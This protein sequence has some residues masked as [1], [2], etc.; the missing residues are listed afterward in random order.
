MSLSNNNIISNE[1]SN[2]N[3]IETI[4]NSN[5]NNNNLMNSNQNNPNQDQD[6]QKTEN[7]LKIQKKIGNYILLDTIGKGTFSKVTLGYHIQTN[8]TVAIKILEKDK[9]QDKIDIER[10]NREITILKLLYHPNISQLYETLSTSHNFYIMMEYI[11]GGDLFEYISTNN[12]L[13][14][15]K[16]C[17]YFRQLISAI[18]YLN[19]LGIAHRDI[20][21]ENI[22]LNSTKTTL[23][24]IDFGLSNFCGKDEMLNSSCGSPCYASPEMIS[25]YPYYGLISDIWS[26]GIVLYCMLIGSL[27]FDDEN[28]KILY[29][30]ITEGKF[31]VPSTLSNEAIDLLKKLLCVNPQKRITLN[32]IKNHVW[33]NMDKSILYKG[34]FLKEKKINVDFNVVHKIKEK[35]F[36]EDINVTENTIAQI[37]RNNGCNKYS[38]TYHLYLKMYNKKLQ[39]DEK[40]LNK[41][42]T[43]ILEIKFK[44]KRDNNIFGNNI[45]NYDKKLNVVVINNIISNSSSIKNIKKK[46][47]IKNNNKNNNHHNKNQKNNNNLAQTLN[48]NNNNNTRNNS[49]NNN[50]TPHSNK[51][52]NNINNTKKK[53]NTNLK[54]EILTD[55]LRHNKKKAKIKSYS[56]VN[57]RIK[58][59]NNTKN[60]II[61]NKSFNSTY[62]NNNNINN[63]NYNNRYHNYYLNNNSNNKNNNKNIKNCNNNNNSNVMKSY[64]NFTLTSNNYT[65]NVSKIFEQNSLNSK[66]NFLKR[67][68]SN[69]LYCN[70]F[71][72]KNIKTDIIS[73]DYEYVKKIFNKKKTRNL[74]LNNNNNT[75]NNIN[76]MNNNINIIFS[77]KNKNKFNNNINN[78]NYNFISNNNN[79][80]NNNNNNFLN[81]NYR[82]YNKYLSTDIVNKKVIIQPNNNNKEKKKKEILD[83]LFLP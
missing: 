15:Q 67:D 26:C 1:I 43:G 66:D 33:F 82:T 21:P 18:E 31:Y 27:P 50:S 74:S 11:D 60:N 28:L 35:F 61:N 58:S 42:N 39:E 64:L 20:K 40:N 55:T 78:N 3:N 47:K 53:K 10:I 9:I 7:T 62:F 68:F 16:S 36:K 29:D 54:L 70:K 4:N 81:V 17:K 73:S 72:N 45:N 24:L 23:K 34:I 79:N 41:N 76:N 75:S 44:K 22:L 71:K 37:V 49:T 57:R 19:K 63:N 52:N 80:I 51:N 2:N 46:I 13:S 32:E 77:K 38:A 8:Q 48:N 6:I 12:Y 14:E 5:T 65:R 59:S 83:K 25:G 30:Q 69:P 56:P